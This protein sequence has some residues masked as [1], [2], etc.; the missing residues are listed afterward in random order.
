MLQAAGLAVESL[1][2]SLLEGRTLSME[3]E[4][5]AKWSAASL[6]SGGA[7]TVGPSLHMGNCH[8]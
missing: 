2:L 1:S 4:H 8:I 3:E 5:L 7:D 6:Y